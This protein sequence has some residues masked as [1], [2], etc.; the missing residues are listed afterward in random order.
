MQKLF[1]KHSKNKNFVGLFAEIIDKHYPPTKKKRQ[2]KNLLQCNMPHVLLKYGA[3]VL[4]RIKSRYFN[5]KKFCFAK[6]F[7]VKISIFLTS[8]VA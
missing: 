3:K 4:F 1:E 5:N 6:L 8:F 7:V 2:I